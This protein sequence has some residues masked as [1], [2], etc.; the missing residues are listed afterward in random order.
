[1]TEKIRK[2]TKKIGL[3][4]EVCVCVCIYVCL[5]GR[6]LGV[7]ALRTWVHNTLK[8]EI[9]SY[10][11]E[12][13]CWLI[14]NFTLLHIITQHIYNNIWYYHLANNSVKIQVKMRADFFSILKF[15]S[16][17]CVMKEWKSFS[18]VFFS[19]CFFNKSNIFTHVKTSTNK[20]GMKT[21][22]TLYDKMVKGQLM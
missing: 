4:V 16:A 13:F 14:C 3:V 7:P 12:I 22:F 21:Y 20:P 8:N 5:E 18:W 9:Y 19:F 10:I 1:M 11:S 17:G 2:N 15:F 6:R